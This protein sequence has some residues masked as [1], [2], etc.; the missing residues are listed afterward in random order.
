[1]PSVSQKSG[2]GQARERTT[3][4]LLDDFVPFQLAVA[5][6]LVSQMIARLIERK[7]DLQLP[8]W[9]I[10]VTLNHFAALAPNEIVEKTAMDKARVSRAQR[11]LTDLKLVVSEE[12]LSDGRRKLLHLSPV[13]VAICQDI[14]PDALA[15][16]AWLLETLSAQERRMLDRILLKLGSRAASIAHDAPAKKRT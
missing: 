6:N 9:R 7:F 3:K 11:R 10:L 2:V 15:S 4:L 8:E 5:A 13:G 1:M 16:E 12:D 14:I